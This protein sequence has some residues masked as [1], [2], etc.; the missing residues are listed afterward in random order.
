MRSKYFFVLLAA[1]LLITNA[2]AQNNEQTVSGTVQDQTG[3]S[4]AGAN[5]SLLSA[6]QLVLQAVTSGANG[7]FRFETVL[8]GSYLVR[9][10]HPGFGPGT[11][12]VQVASKSVKL[13]LILQVI[14][15]PATVTVTAETNTA[16]DRINIPAQINL[17][18]EDAILQRTPAVLAQV[19]NEETGV[20]LQR[21]SPTIG[22]IL[23][24]GLT[25]VGVYV[26]GVRYTNSTQRGGINTF[27]NLNEPTVIR[28]VE[29]QRSPNTAQFGSDGLGG[30]AQ[31][32]S[33]Q[34]DYGMEKPQW[35]GEY[36]SYFN[37]ADHSFG[38]NLLTGYG[39][40][41]FGILTNLSAR[42]INT[43]RPGGGRD[44]H[45]AI[46][47]FLGLPSDITGSERLPDTAFT[48][49]GGTLHL[50]FALTDDR[51]ISFR[52]Q[53]SQQD[54][55]KRYDQLLGGD[56]N[57]IAELKNLMLD[58]SYLRYYKQA[59][60]FFDNLS[61]TVSYNSQREERINQGGNGN[62]LAAITND[63][64]RTTT[65]GASFF[66]DKQ[67]ARNSLL[68]G[69]DFYHDRV[70][71]PSFNTEPALGIQVT[72]VRPRVPN[73]A[74]YDLFGIYLQNS[75]EAI[76]E[77]LRLSGA[78]RYN[79]G[80]Y[81]SSA[82]DAPSVNGQPLFPDDS[83]RFNDFSGRIGAVVTITDGLNAA[84]NFSRGFRAP[85]I[86]SLGSLGLVGVGFQVST[87]SVAGLNA[88]VGTTADA[89]AVSTGVPVS[90][91]KSEISNNYE[92]SLRFRRPKIEAEFTGFLIE[93][94]DAIVRQALILPPGAVGTQL[95]NQTIT[96]QTAH[97]AVFVALSTSPVLVQTNL[98]R[99]RLYGTEFS[100]QY[101]FAREWSTGGN[102]STLYAEDRA[103][104]L[105]P[106]LGGGGVPPTLG[107]LRLRYQSTKKPFWIEAYANFAGQQD[108]LSSL[109]LSDRRTG[110][111]RSRAQIQNFFRRG[112]C[113]RGLIAPGSNGQCNTA[114][115][116]LIAT[117][118]TLAQVQDRLLPLGATI[119]G[120]LVVD[121]NT[122][123]PLLTSIP[124][125]VLFNLRGGYTFNEKHQLNLSFENI[126]DRSN[127]LPG[128][129]IDGPGRSLR[130]A[131]RLRF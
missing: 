109:D 96:S 90:P 32:I 34:P 67:I 126:G 131:Y 128:W 6:Q 16:N 5:V 88:T 11:K 9:V 53:R 89:N 31:L 108:R 81:K 68:I 56:G 110:G 127:R 125:Y 2:A 72:P 92:G 22:A 65:W 117:G 74:R 106:S 85:N 19:V 76:S 50:N 97:G 47:R 45:S 77:R 66:V 17:V 60:G 57:L 51:Q 78:L 95:G 113:L 103:N 91:L 107:F 3:A 30:N 101:R 69:G 46:T 93:Y 63:K 35:S 52:Y 26:D 100:A 55:G 7:D 43:L 84:F 14:A 40:R 38:G 118:E 70:R 122:A 28:S 27:F 79:L 87:S 44:G 12:A 116:I 130:V 62:P 1:C 129:G 123:V 24:R 13:D 48:Q 99:S 37:S 21:T 59:A 104:G 83:A 98:N 41:R 75:F 49:Y 61:A 80:A 120:V 42:R 20:S 102:F 39:R 64:E 115:G 94:K 10:L 73:G 15:A 121:N 23:V 25:E 114:G 86:T 18:T 105:P 112:A 8:P 119:N 33:R 29:I 71:A 82:A 4:V 124:G 111:A 36:N 58:F 54:G